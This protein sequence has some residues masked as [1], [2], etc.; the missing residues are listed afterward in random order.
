MHFG[1]MALRQHLIR[2]PVGLPPSP[3]E[4]GFGA[5]NQKK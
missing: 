3:Q 4:E 1:E 2:Q 5:Q